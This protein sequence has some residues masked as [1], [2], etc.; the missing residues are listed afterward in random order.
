MQSEL[1]SLFKQTHKLDEKGKSSPPPDR[2]AREIEEE[3]EEE[4]EQEV[5]L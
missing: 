5:L 4:V 3:A 1:T 2:V